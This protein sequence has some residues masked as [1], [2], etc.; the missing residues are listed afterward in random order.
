MNDRQITESKWTMSILLIVCFALFFWAMDNRNE[1]REA[2]FDASNALISL[3]QARRNL[4]MNVAHKF[5][6]DHSLNRVFTDPCTWDDDT[7]SRC[8]ALVDGRV[9][10]FICDES[11]CH[12]TECGKEK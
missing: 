1:A 4:V 7:T 11:D 8:T 5:T 2:R 6:I 9:Q 3:K 12:F 10:S